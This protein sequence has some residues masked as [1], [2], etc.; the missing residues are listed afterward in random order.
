V[1]PEVVARIGLDGGFERMVVAD[2]NGDKHPDILLTAI[3]NSGTSEQPVTVLVNDGHGGFTNQTRTL[4]TNDVPVTLNS[5]TLLVADF[6]SDGRPDVFIADWGNDAPPFP[7]AQNRLILSAPGGH[8]VDA[9]ANLPQASDLS[10]S[11]CAADVNGDGHMDIYVSNLFGGDGSPPR[12]LLG[13][14]TGHFTVSTGLDAGLTNPNF[15]QNRYTQCALADVN[16]DGSPDLV[17][18]AIKTNDNSDVFLNDGAGDFRFLPNALPAKPL[19]PSADAQ[20]FVATDINHD[21]HLDLLIPFTH[22]TY[23]GAWIQVLIGNGDG[24]F[25]DETQTRLPQT[26][27][28][29]GTVI[30]S[31]ELVDLN[32]DGNPDFGAH[33]GNSN[34]DPPLFFTSDANGVFHVAGSLGLPTGIWALADV[35]GDGRLDAVF[36]NPTGNSVSVALQPGPARALPKCKRGQKP[37]NRHPCRR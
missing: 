32:H 24:T 9:T 35:N 20:G 3:K 37:T 12:L 8:L 34:T 30:S 26:D 16:G 19:E 22:S 7:G 10:G 15:N 5:S 18:G 1:R 14:G 29:R 13:D 6:N 23:I 25:R 4:F 17:L 36:A 21:G 2:L 28:Q 27:S 33:F 31:V 11:A